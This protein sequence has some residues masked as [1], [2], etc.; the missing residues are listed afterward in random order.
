MDMKMINL[1]YHEDVAVVKLNRGITNPISLQLIEELSEVL[2]EMKNA[3]Q[4]HSMVLS[5]SN[6]KFFSIGFDIPELFKLNKQDFLVFYRTFNKTCL[7]L[8][9]LPMPTIA[10]VN[11]HAIAGGCILALCCDYRVIA[12]GRKL[13]GLNEIKLGVPVPYTA[14]CILRSLVGVRYARE[15]MD[16]GEFYEPSESL[17]TGMIDHILPPDEVLPF[18]I[19]MAEELGSW[20]P[21]AFAIIKRN[22]VETVQ[23]QILLHLEEREDLFLACWYSDRARDLLKE[24]VEK[25]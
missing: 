20:S 15:I 23:E 13:M 22:R 18:S 14:D 19:R 11:G 4:V 5:S 7:E 21:G 16:K 8:Y 17:R 2:K 10:A 1:E 9:T 12:D 25:F 6:E 3:P 24:A